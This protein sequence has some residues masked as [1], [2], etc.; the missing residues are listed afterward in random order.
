ME[1]FLGPLNTGGEGG[2]E[3]E[4]HKAGKKSRRKGK[5]CEVSGHP[6]LRR[7]TGLKIRNNLKGN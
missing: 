6:N 5:I 2:S 7:I 4:R 1:A 3:R